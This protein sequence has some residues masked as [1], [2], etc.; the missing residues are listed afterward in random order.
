MNRGYRPDENDQ[1]LLGEAFTNP[2]AATYARGRL[3]YDRAYVMKVM[4]AYTAPGPFRASFV[5]RYQ[6]G[7]PFS[8]V[9]VAEGLNQGAEIIH[10]YPRGLQRFTFTLTLDARAE[11]QWR[12]GGRRSLGVAADAFNLLG[13]ANEV[14]EDVVTGPGFRTVTAVQ[15]PRVI[16]LGLRLRF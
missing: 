7:Q 4:G 2:N 10:T 14:E 5:A 1:G 15:P 9:V 16:R 8:R 3:F 12:F 11:L 6:D 13:T